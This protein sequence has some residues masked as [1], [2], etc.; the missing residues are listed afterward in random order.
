MLD[1]TAPIVGVGLAMRWLAMK[2]RLHKIPKVN[3]GL[4]FTYREELRR[5][6][7]I[8]GEVDGGQDGYAHRHWMAKKKVERILAIFEIPAPSVYA[9]TETIWL[10][11]MPLVIDY[12]D[13]G[14][15]EGAK[16]IT[17]DPN[18]RFMNS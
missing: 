11:F 13:Q 17:A 5:Q 16:G 10:H 14:D 7:D 4:F 9:D 8:L 15:L 12:S 3:R 2:C 6:F 18:K 1:L